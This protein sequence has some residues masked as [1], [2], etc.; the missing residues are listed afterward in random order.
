MHYELFYW[1]MLQGRGEFVRLA[2]ED[3]E[4]DYT[5][6]ARHGQGSH[7]GMARMQQVLE[8]EPDHT[9][10]DSDKHDNGDSSG[11]KGSAGG[12]ALPFE[13]PFAPPF[14]KARPHVVSQT[15]NILQFLGPRLSLVP[16]DAASRTFINGLQL[17]IAD[18][19]TEAHD[20]HHPIASSLYYEDQKAAAKA[21]AG[22][23]IDQRIPKF[24]GYFQRVIER[25]PADAGW[26]VGH[27]ASY[28]DL[29]LFQL[30]EGLH[31]AFPKGLHD[32]NQRYPMLATLRE[33]VAARPGLKR[34]LAS[35]RR[36]AF[37]EEGIFR[38]YPELDRKAHV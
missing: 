8:S 37:N 16:E 27:Q 5:D 13:L 25:N 19:V 33:N 35:K 29:S 10:D 11:T 12:I 32:F 2:L 28:A 4:A 23:F 6:I 24:L 36:I 31:Y 26:L 15:A 1:P 38:H 18:A 30:I 21:R 22:D 20:T 34:Y 17:T 3:A 14:L 7:G 9:G